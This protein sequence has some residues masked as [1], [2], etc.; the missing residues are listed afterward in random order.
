MSL[1]LDA[2]NKADQERKRNE[3]TPGIN[4]N[5]GHTGDHSNRTISIVAIAAALIG[6]AILLAAI[7]WLGQRSSATAPSTTAA[8]SASAPT[9]NQALITPTIHN[10]QSTTASQAPENALQETIT[11]E[12][13]VASLYAQNTQTTES[14]ASAPVTEGIATNSNG[15]SEVLPSTALPSTE[16]PSTVPPITPTSISQF[17][18]LPDLHDLPSQILIKIPSLNY[19]E[20]NYNNVSGSVKINGEIKH[21]NDQLAPGLVIDKIL[22]DGMI[23]HLDNYSFKM[24]ALNSWVNM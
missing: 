3:A 7:Y 9:V 17:A 2:L 14:P 21:I 16:L 12:Q 24:R 19:S 20:H 11:P 5:H 18:N 4:S 1:L 15:N 23:L 8:I 10:K 13:D 22:E 6:F